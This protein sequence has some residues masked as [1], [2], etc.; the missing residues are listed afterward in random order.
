L[1]SQVKY[2]TNDKTLDGKWSI[3]YEEWPWNQYPH[4]L[5]GGAVLI[6]GSSIFPLLAASQTIPMIPFDDLYFFG[7]CT[8]KAVIKTYFSSGSTR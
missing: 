7:M 8:E 5:L 2:L 4:Y 1:L 3:T 6:H